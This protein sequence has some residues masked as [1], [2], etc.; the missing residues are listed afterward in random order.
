MVQDDHEDVCKWS[1]FTNLEID[2]NY[3]KLT[4]TSQFFLP[5]KCMQVEDFDYLVKEI[6]AHLKK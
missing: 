3:L 1:A 5:K 2:G 6:K 4:G